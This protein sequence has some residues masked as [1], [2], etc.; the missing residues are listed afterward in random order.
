MIDTA[1][2]GFHDIQSGAIGLA[3]TGALIYQSLTPAIEMDR[4]MGEL[5]STDLQQSA[6]KDLGYAAL[7]LS[8]SYGTAANEI[9]S[10][11]ADISRSI[12]GLTDS[13]YVAF[14]EASAILAASTKSVMNE[15]TKYVTQ[16]YH[17][18]QDTADSMGRA[19]WVDQL[20]GKTAYLKKNLGIKTAEMAGAME[21]LN[22]L[23]TGLGVSMQ[24]QMS[25][26]AV[27]GQSTGITEAEQQYTNFLEYVVSA[28]DKLGMSFI[29]SN[30]KLL[31]MLTILEMLQ[32]EFGN[33]EGAET[34][35]ILD[36]AFGDGSKLIQ[37]LSKDTEKLN[38]TMA[39]MG[40][41]KNIDDAIAMAE[42]M[43]DPW[44]QMSAGIKSV[45]V[46]IGQALLPVINPIIASFA[47][48]SMEILLWTRMFPNLTKVIGIT[49]LVILSLGASMA[50][51][52]IAVGIGK[53]SWSGFVMVMKLVKTITLAV[54]SAQWLL[55]VAFMSS[56]IGLIV[57]G[58]TAMVAAAYAVWM[59]IKS[60]WNMF[61][62]T[63]SGQAFIA[64]IKSTVGWFSSLGDI[65]EWV[66]D[67][68][69][70]IPGV[71]IGAE[72]EQP[73][74]PRETMMSPVMDV[75]SMNIEIPYRQESMANEVPAGGVT[76]Q[77]SKSISDNSNKNTQ[78]SIST[79]QAM[80]PAL[81]NEFL[82][83][84]GA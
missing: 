26:L 23:G 18:F 44:K 68:I 36:D 69:D 39:E 6:I 41:I 16:M 66:I 38:T 11:S 48:F 81:L 21:G 34:W 31:P 50:A 45:N 78:V 72:S 59:G 14:T 28:Q 7:E 42:S 57:V 82:M 9:I 62:E 58:L 22:N 74:L 15:T 2:K 54:T 37:Q 29:D 84:E 47:K 60:L 20:V 79:S 25:V 51:L 3:A 76:Q 80:S 46:A 71:S 13:E 61:S 4:A 10:S 73:E 1:K 52:T 64:L 27:L 32:E 12:S 49:T 40:K 30:G 65:V 77:I 70:L 83:M 35:A 24:E 67:Q 19:E 75:D 55:N 53:A 33:L 56:F 17:R 8:A 5:E 43:T 63:S